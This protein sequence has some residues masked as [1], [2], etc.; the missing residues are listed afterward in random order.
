MK[1]SIEQA[2][3]AL[4]LQEERL[5]GLVFICRFP[6]QPLG[7]REAT[8]NAWRKA[9]EM[10]DLIYSMMETDQ[11]EY[12]ETIRSNGSN[13]DFMKSVNIQLPRKGTHAS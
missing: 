9:L 7:S 5:E 2:K 13:V 10:L 3:D 11:H 4:Y 6:I 12:V 1:V 8:Q